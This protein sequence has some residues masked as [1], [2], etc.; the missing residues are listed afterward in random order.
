MLRPLE[1]PP[2][3]PPQ[4][5]KNRPRLLLRR[6]AGCAT[7]SARL[8]QA[9][10]FTR[11]SFLASTWGSAY[12]LTRL[13]YERSSR[14]ART[15][16]GIHLRLLGRYEQVAMCLTSQRT[17]SRHFGQNA[18]CARMGRSGRRAI[19][20]GAHYLGFIRPPPT[21]G[22]ITKHAKWLQFW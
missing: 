4:Q 3:P 5:T 20:G 6:V 21:M 19:L 16:G 11:A 2:L 9:P 13:Y 1:T 14:R 12:V 8:L 17:P 15:P 22:R 7:G 10:I 18:W